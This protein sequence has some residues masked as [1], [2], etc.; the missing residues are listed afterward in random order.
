VRD[1]GAVKRKRVAVD[2]MGGN[3]SPVAEIEGAIAATNARRIPITLVGDQQ[4]IRAEL[5]RL[6]V[7]DPS[8]QVRH[9]T[10]VITMEDHPGQVVRRK[11][12]ASMRVCFDLARAGEVDALVSA[13]NSGAFLACGLFVMKRLAGV[14][15][16]GIVAT[17]PNLAGKVAVM[18]VGANVDVQ[19]PEILAQFAVMA[20]TFSRVLYKVARPRVALLS[21]GEEAH[22]GS[23]LT[24]AVHDILSRAAELPAE[25]DYVGYCEGNDIFKQPLDV[26]VTDGFTGNVIL[27]TTEGIAEAMFDLIRQEISAT[28]TRQLLARLLKPAFKAIQ[29]RTDWAEYGGAPL[30]GVD[31]VAVL[32]HGRSSARAIENAITMAA[33]L[34]DVD[35][36]PT[37]TEAIARHSA[38]YAPRPAAAAAAAPHEKEGEEGSA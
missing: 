1:S 38:L 23:L 36:R 20:A 31:G 26:V 33:D 19:K 14:D 13:G 4:R 11:K 3:N 5:A 17:F 21:N 18:D 6:G 27:K 9:T 16:P 29:K 10:E 22:K 25:F 30:L 37:M 8:I 32:C 24:R 7:A 12:D 2:A 15:R 35:M 34:A 28:M